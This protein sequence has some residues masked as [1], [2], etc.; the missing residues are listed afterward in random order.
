MEALKKNQGGWVHEVLTLIERC[1]VLFD[2]V[3]ENFL[4]PNLEIEYRENFLYEAVASLVINMA[5]PYHT[6]TPV[7]Q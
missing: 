3:L 6:K 4:C 5:L 2:F 7:I 1:L